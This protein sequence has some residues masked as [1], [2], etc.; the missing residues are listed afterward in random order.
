MGAL[1]TWP[2]MNDPSTTC[3]FRSIRD[4]LYAMLRVEAPGGEG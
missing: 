3:Q 2:W 1:A 4:G